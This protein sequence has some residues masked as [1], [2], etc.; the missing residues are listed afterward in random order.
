MAV[1]P[2]GKQILY[3]MNSPSYWS[4][5]L[6]QNISHIHSSQ[7]TNGKHNN[8]T[9]RNAT[10][11][12][13]VF[14]AL[15]ITSLMTQLTCSFPY[16]GIIAR[17]SSTNKLITECPKVVINIEKI[18]YHHV[19]QPKDKLCCNS[20]WVYSNTEYQGPHQKAQ[21]VDLLFPTTA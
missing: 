9:I 20:H 10:S 21:K 3:F 4:C 2:G 5:S 8:V 6:T 13:L 17:T 1:V 19:T 11:G 12:P 18:L 7:V 14:N 15:P 16:M